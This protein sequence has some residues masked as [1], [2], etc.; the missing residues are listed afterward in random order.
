MNRNLFHQA[1]RRGELRIENV[2]FELAC[3]KKFPESGEGTAKA[4][5]GLG[6]GSG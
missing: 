6:S 5:H 1:Q 2:R 4:V 3:G